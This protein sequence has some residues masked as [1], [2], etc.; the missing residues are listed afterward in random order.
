VPTNIGNVKVPKGRNF[1]NDT[2]TL[3]RD[4]RYLDPYG[5]HYYGHPNSPYFY[6]WLAAANDDDDDNDPLPP[7]NYDDSECGGGAFLPIPFALGF[8]AWMKR[9]RKV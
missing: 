7:Q 1:Y 9:R 6:L 3:R 2:N 8:M 4:P 5:P